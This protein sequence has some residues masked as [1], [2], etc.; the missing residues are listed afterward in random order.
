MQFTDPVH[1]RLWLM[2]VA[3]APAPNLVDFVDQLGVVQAVARLRSALP[4]SA[5]DA[6]LAETG[7]RDA[8]ISTDLHALDTGA[9]QLLIPEAPGWPCC[10]LADLDRHKLGSPLGLWVHGNPAALARHDTLA[11]VGARAATSYGEHVASDLAYHLALA[12]RGVLCG[13]SFGIEAAA[14]RAV[15]TVHHA[16]PPVVVLGH[17]V[18]T[19]YPRAHEQLFRQV[20]NHGGALVSEH[21]PGTHPA[22]A[23]LHARGRL[24]AALTSHTVVVEAG[25]RSGALHVATTAHTLGRPVYGVPGPITNA[26]SRGVHQLLADG[27]AQLVCDTEHLLSCLTAD[28]TPQ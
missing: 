27:T 21:P 1:A 10:A 11:V 13:G 18:D 2:R 14:L 5:P 17:G 8:D 16:P 15:L 22:K 6:V 12:G 3:T 24:L 19:V 26:Q 9:A 7:A 4:G 28:H 23:R 25:R 20:L